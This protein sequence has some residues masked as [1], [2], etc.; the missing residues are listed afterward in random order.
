MQFAFPRRFWSATFTQSIGKD[1]W[2]SRISWLSFKQVQVG[3]VWYPK[4]T[5]LPFNWNG[6]QIWRLWI[7]KIYLMNLWSTSDTCGRA[8]KKETNPAAMPWQSSLAVSRESLKVG[9]C[10][11]QSQD[12]KVSSKCKFMSSWSISDVTMS[13]FQFLAIWAKVMTECAY[14]GWGA[15][16]HDRLDHG[17]LVRQNGNIFSFDESLIYGHLPFEKPLTSHNL[18][19]NRR[20]PSSSSSSASFRHICGTYRTYLWPSSAL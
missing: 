14:P 2:S 13:L 20:G 3:C 11:S 19:F 8:A 17:Q 9:C 6:W 18:H 1:S 16:V 5:S 10:S 4:P 7:M 12:C 15:E